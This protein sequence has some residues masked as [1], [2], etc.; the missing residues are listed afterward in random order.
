MRKYGADWDKRGIILQDLGI[1]VAPEVFIAQGMIPL[2]SGV[3]ILEGTKYFTW[4]VAMELVRREHGPKGWRLPTAEES[5]AIC[6]YANSTGRRIPNR[7]LNG[8]VCSDKVAE[9]CRFPIRDS[10]LITSHGNVGY[11]WTSSLKVPSYP[12]AIFSSELSMGG[13]VS[14][15]SS[16][17]LSIL[18]VKDLQDN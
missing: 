17:G 13:I 16:Y 3:L 5:S 9:Y 12:Y 11:Y 1:V 7:R 6:E 8:F 14:I 4:N 15:Y 2:N 10:P 18:L